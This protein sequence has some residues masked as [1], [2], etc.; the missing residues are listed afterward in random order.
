MRVSR[1]VIVAAIA[2]TFGFSCHNEPEYQQ[3]GMSNPPGG[4]GAAPAPAAAAAA[5]PSNGAIAGN[6]ATTAPA[7]ATR[8]DSAKG[9]AKKRP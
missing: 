4:S 9:A 2:S 5:V 8:P 3:Q 1:L 7:K 6:T